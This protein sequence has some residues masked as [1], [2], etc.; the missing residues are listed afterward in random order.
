MVGPKEMKLHHLAAL[1]LL[2]FC[3]ETSI[4]PTDANAEPPIVAQIRI[5]GNQRIDE[6]AILLHISQEADQPLDE[7]AVNDDI[8]SIYEMGFFSSISAKLVS[9]N[10]EPALV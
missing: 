8:R 9:I 3:F 10:D 7:S 4:A 5:E 2:G 1:S 6:D